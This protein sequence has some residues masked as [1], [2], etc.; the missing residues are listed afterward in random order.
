MIF[1]NDKNEICSDK[2]RMTKALK[3]LIFSPQNNF[4]VFKDGI[5]IYGESVSIHSFYDMLF[6]CF[7]QLDSI[8]R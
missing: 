4:K 6:E 5:H 8:N 7:E 2:E 3:S 1:L